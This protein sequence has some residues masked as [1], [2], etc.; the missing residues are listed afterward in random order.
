M[1]NI[2]M[3]WTE[4]VDELEIR[5]GLAAVQEIASE[6]QLVSFYR[7]L[8]GAA[9][10]V[11]VFG[12]WSIPAMPEGAPYQSLQWYIDQ[13]YDRG[14]GSVIG[15]RLLDIV[16]NEPWQRSN[17]HYDLLLISQKL[18]PTHR[19][20]PD[21][22]ALA[23]SVPGRA[24]VIS[25]APLRQIGDNRMRL[26]TIRRVVGHQL[27]HLFGIPSATRADIEINSEGERHC[28]QVCAMREAN[29]LD[30]LVELSAEEIKAKVLFCPEC[31]QD[32]LT[33]MAD[34]YFGVN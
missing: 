5:F 20:A 23:L 2:S 12:N 1:Q 29:D 15:S 6:L 34:S 30:Q 11:N 10:T 16:L 8:H 13:S 28:R 25:A 4:N 3:V 27:G 17:A 26:Y 22:Q 18:L 19:H 24:T 33:V 14:H 7:G 32:L 21:E 9:P 31:W